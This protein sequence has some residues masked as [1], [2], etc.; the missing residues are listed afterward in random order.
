MFKPCLLGMLLLLFNQQTQG[1]TNPLTINSLYPKGQGV[2]F[3]FASPSLQP[4]SSIHIVHVYKGPSLAVSLKVLSVKKD[5]LTIQQT[6]LFHKISDT[7]LV[8]SYPDGIDSSLLNDHRISVVRSENILD[9][10]PVIS[11][12]TFTRNTTINKGQKDSAQAFQKKEKQKAV[13][14]HGQVMVDAQLADGKMLYQVQPQHYMRTHVNAEVEVKGLPFD[15]GYLYT[16]ES[17]VNAISNFRVSFNHAKFFASLKEKMNKKIELDA[18][19]QLNNALPIDIGAVNT[20]HALLTNKFSSRDFQN[21]M[22][23]NK[24]LLEYGEMTP[25]FKE[26]RRYKKAT[27]ELDSFGIQTSRLNVL[28]SIR[29]KYATFSDNAALD[30]NRVKIDSYKSDREFKRSLRRYSLNEGMNPAFLDIKKLD[31]GMCSP[32]YNL[33]IINGVSFNGINTE[34]NPGNA[35]GAFMWGSTVHNFGNPFSLDYSSGRSIM[36]GRLGVGRSEKLLFAITVLSGEDGIKNI[37]KDSQNA[38]VP[39]SNYVIG[40]ELRYKTDNLEAGMEYAQAANNNKQDEGNE[41]NK[42]FSSVFEKDRV[43]HSKAWCGYGTY[44]VKQTNTRLKFLTKIIDPFYYSFGTPYLRQDNF[45]MELKGEQGFVKNKLIAGVTYRRDEDNL[46]ELKKVSTTYHSFIYTIQARFKK[47]PFV[48]LLY[49]PN[50]QA[51]DNRLNN[52][53]ISGQ[54]KLYQATINH[55]SRWKYV[56]LTNTFSYMRQESSSVS[57]SVLYNTMNQY[58]LTE[59]LNFLKYALQLNA[60]VSYSRYVLA[61]AP[62][63]GLFYTNAGLTKGLFKNKLSVTAGYAYQQDYAAETRSVLSAGSSFSLPYSIRCNIGLEKHIVKNSVGDA[64]QMHFGRIT[65]IKP[66]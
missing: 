34:L 42:S 10:Y 55:T 14:I 31:I 23:K 44:S 22:A 50:Y 35:Y 30:A 25:S 28:D 53:R 29:N 48:A 58:S 60:S 41:I 33:L 51:Y 3:S 38:Y 15:V 16:T 62:S 37:I 61:G 1:Q 54:V 20:E 26:T 47:L 11:T 6:I 43:K 66:F 24:R 45:R 5:S 64:Q 9:E 27:V 57:D 36:A 19:R 59:G 40:A 7:L 49:S 2:L 17:P 39:F 12:S 52:Q 32:D 65:I 56:L 46:Y 63:S 13:K 8:A 4:D 21:E 18:A